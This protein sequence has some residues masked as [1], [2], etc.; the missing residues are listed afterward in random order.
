MTQKTIVALDERELATVLAALRYWQREGWRG[1]CHEQVIAT[2]D[3]DFSAMEADEID[4]LCERINTADEA[5]P[6]APMPL[7]ERLHALATESEPDAAAILTE[8][9]GAVITMVAALQSANGA[10]GA[11]QTQI[12][13]MSDWFT[14]EDGTLRQALDDAE[15]TYSI[16]GQAIAL[17]TGKEG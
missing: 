7:A 4:T 13:Q 3:G 16:I 9:G 5:K 11:L 6:S 8:A 2:N 15:E 12:D 17:A 1:D 10:M 14:D